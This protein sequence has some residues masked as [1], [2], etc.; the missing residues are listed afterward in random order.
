MHWTL[1][2][3]LKR[4]YAILGRVHWSEVSHI[5]NPHSR[6]MWCTILA[7][8][9]RR[10]IFVSSPKNCQD[11]IEAMLNEII[12]ASFNDDESYISPD[13]EGRIKS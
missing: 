12:G 11:M 2:T 8:T 1:K 10:S 4:I 3:D 7:Y 9:E 5:S 6:V 13:W